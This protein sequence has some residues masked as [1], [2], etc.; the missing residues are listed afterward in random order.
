MHQ[1]FRA[2]MVFRRPTFHEV[3]SQGKR[4]SNETNERL[5]IRELI[6]NDANSLCHLRDV[7]V[8]HRQVAHILWGAHGMC[9]HRTAPRNNF[10]VNARRFQGDDDVR[11]QNC[12]IDI[13]ASD[14]LH[15]NFRKHVGL[16]TRIQHAGS[17]AQLAIFR[18]AP[19][20]LAHKPHGGTARG[21]AVS[22]SKERRIIQIPT[23]HSP[24]YPR[25][26][27]LER[28]RNQRLHG[29]Q[30]NSWGQGHSWAS[31]PWR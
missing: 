8:K 5:G 4:G 17:F 3:A 1:R 24:H 10:D 19:A 21:A 30:G 15:G 9:H 27:D 22:S 29:N 2:L 20:S 16:K 26:S 14:W 28:N 23:R 11:K 25:G 6:Q 13:V 31:G 12:G 7:V 18:K